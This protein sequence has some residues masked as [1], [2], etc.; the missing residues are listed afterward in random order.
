[1]HERVPPRPHPPFHIRHR[2]DGHPTLPQ[3]LHAHL[4][5]QS[6]PHVIRRH[7]LAHHVRK[8]RGHMKESPRP[9][10]L[11]MHQRDVSHR[12][13]NARPQ[14]PQPVISAFLQPRQT[15]PRILHR[16]TI[17]LQRQSNIRPHQLVRALMSFR[18]PPVVVRQTHLQRRN[19][20]PLQ[21]AAQRRLPMPLR[22]P[23]RQNQ[24]RRPNLL[25]RKKL[26]VHRIVFCPSR[27]HRARK[28]QHILRIQPVIPHLL[29][30]IPRL[31]L[32]RSLPR[33][34]P[35]IRPRLLVLC[36]FS[37]T[38]HSPPR[39]D[40]VGVATRHFFEML[41][42]PFKRPHHPVVIGGPPPVLVP[43]YPML[44]PAHRHSFVLSSL[45]LKRR[46]KKGWLEHCLV[47]SVV[48]RLFLCR[49]RQETTQPGMHVL[50]ISRQEV[51][52]L[53]IIPGN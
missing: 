5:P 52:F 1:H 2:T 37:S 21:P 53:P 25:P 30:R 38:S 15:R 49:N 48:C 13:P 43:P 14:N 35:H 50:A 36:S 24:H 27:F 20:H 40:P 10:P 29:R 31:A 32:R 26:R 28:R 4:V 22:I 41:K 19:P 45:R 17:R 8:I 47:E 11:V 9:H 6:F 33:V 3:L 39:P 42:S 44:V 16:L 51:F 34:L 23:V 7:P 18:H 12:R 46:E